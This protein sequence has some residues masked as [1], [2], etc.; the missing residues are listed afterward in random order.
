MEPV[1]EPNITIDQALPINAKQY[2][3]FDGEKINQ[4]TK[5]EHDADI[6]EAVRNI[7][8]LPAIERARKHLRNI[9]KEFLAKLRKTAKN[10]NEEVLFEAKQEIDQGIE[11][12]R[13]AE[14]DSNLKLSQVRELK[15]KIEQDLRKQT[16]VKEKTKR[17]DD[18][19]RSY[20]ACEAGIKSNRGRVAETLASSSLILCGKL[21]N[22]TAGLLEKRREKIHIPPG[23]REPFIMDLIETG[24][25]ICGND[26]SEGSDGKCRIE[27]FMNETRASTRIAEEISEI[28]ADLGQVKRMSNELPEV[29]KKNL[30]DWMRAVEELEDIAGRLEDVHRE[31]EKT[32]DTD[33]EKLAKGLRECE[34]D[35]R[36]IQ[37][38]L[39]E[40]NLKIKELKA[41]ATRI[42]QELKRVTRSKSASGELARLS[43]LAEMS[44]DVFD[45]VYEE[46]ARRKREAIA[47]E[48]KVIFDRLIWKKDQFPDVSLTENY[49]LE[50]YDRYGSPCREELSAGER[51]ILS[52]S[53]ITA[54]A[55][56]TGGTIPLIMD[57]PF[58]RLSAEH[59]NNIVGAIPQL[60]NQ[61]VLLVQ[62]EEVSEEMLEILR[63]RVGKEYQLSF[64][65]GC[66]KIEEI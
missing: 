50:V 34:N 44:V 38:E 24:K 31:L 40:I 1:K 7:L 47:E 52:L 13:Q 29:L 46:F 49:T 48:L 41:H 19:Q 12:A 43:K 63:S 33:I 15:T 35:E 6:K 56:V 22:K 55:F 36:R 62:D 23:I 20:T 9:N 65:D 45:N 2:F 3:L 16:A 51:Q 14:N 10:V 58:G 53:F 18:L 5:P 27:Q 8:Q 54:M 64:E 57:T 66:S 39:A 25:C 37:R 4:L 32:G 21:V 59:R 17:R 30:A 60:T 28:M 61:W 26:L 42:E 11:L